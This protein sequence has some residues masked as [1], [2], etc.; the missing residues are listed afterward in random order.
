MKGRLEVVTRPPKAPPPGGP[1]RTPPTGVDRSLFDAFAKPAFMAAAK[2]SRRMWSLA[3]AL[4]PLPRPNRQTVPPRV[5]GI[6]AAKSQKYG[7]SVLSVVSDAILQKV[8]SYFEEQELV[9][10]RILH[11]GDRSN[12]GILT[13]AYL[14]C[15]RSTGTAMSPDPIVMAMVWRTL[16]NRF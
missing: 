14:V 12:D 3:I 9:C 1:K 15:S 7:E 6:G 10:L 11:S 4:Q 13:R 2:G 5:P 16:R 8:D